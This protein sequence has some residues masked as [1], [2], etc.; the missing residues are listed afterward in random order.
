MYGKI[1]IFNLQLELN[2]LIYKNDN[3]PEGWE[4]G[5]VLN[6][7]NLKEKIHNKAKTEESKINTITDKKI[8]ME[9]MYLIYKELGFVRFVEKTG[10]KY[11]RP[12]LVQNFAK[13]L[14]NFVPKKGKPKT[15][16]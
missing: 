13:Y 11:S 2:K 16:F 7:K 14:D 9:K 6:F 15:K 8:E 10:Y 3:I 12:N 5:R 4:K 1:W